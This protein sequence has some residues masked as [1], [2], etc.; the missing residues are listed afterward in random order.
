MKHSFGKILG[1]S[2]LTAALAVAPAFAT[3]N[4]N[5][6]EPDLNNDIINGQL[7]LGATTADMDLTVYDSGYTDATVA[8]IG[9]SF[10]AELGGFSR[11][12]TDQETVGAIDA[13]LYATAENLSGDMT[14]VSA[15]VGN[16]AS[17]VSDAYL[18]CPDD[19]VEDCP[20]KFVGITIENTQE[21]RY[22]P[23]ATLEAEAWGVGYVDFTSAAIGNSLSVEAA[24]HTNN[25][26]TRQIVRDSVSAY[27][28][29]SVG[30]A[31]GVSATSA[32]VGNTVSID[33]LLD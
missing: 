6:H 7:N 23:S 22:D 24:G 32:A 19:K 10:S 5:N 9:N 29:I 14:L 8:A 31:D 4:H 18:P 33:N 2:A 25:I 17:I 16:T 20:E 26:D 3:G 28:N 30:G 27:S 21:V 15:A 12:V 1:T 11:V 13:K